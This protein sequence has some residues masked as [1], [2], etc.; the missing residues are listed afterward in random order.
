MTKRF[1]ICGP[2]CSGKTTIIGRL[3]RDKVIHFAGDEIGKRLYYERKLN[4]G[5]QKHD[6]EQE[7]A[8]LELA[9]DIEIAGT[10]HI[11]CVET[12]HPGNLAYAAIRN[13]SSVP[14]LAEVCHRSPIL[15]D[16]MGI[17]LRTPIGKI[18]QRTQTFSDQPDWAEDF[19]C[20]IDDQL[21]ACLDLLGLTDK[22]IEVTSSDGLD[23]VYETVSAVIKS[24]TGRH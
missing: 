15:G 19:Y 3:R 20:K 23:A 2:H 5:I 22:T 16:A 24:A 14:A 17:W 11:S 13:P 9:R 18:K 7:V 10:G 1:F 21:G 6:F 12:W 4:T 8:E